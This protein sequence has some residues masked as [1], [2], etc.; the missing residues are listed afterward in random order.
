MKKIVILSFAL[1]PII[2]SAGQQFPCFSDT[3]NQIVNS[4]S[5]AQQIKTN[6]LQNYTNN[7]NNNGN[8]SSAILSSIASCADIT[9]SV[10][11]SFPTVDTFLSLIQKAIQAACNSARTAIA[12]QTQVLTNQLYINPGVAGMP[13][14]GVSTKVSGMSVPSTTTAFAFPTATVNSNPPAP[15]PST[16]TETGMFNQLKSLLGG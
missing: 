1:L 12:A 10:G 3:S 15:A 8:P 16:P 11:F 13:G 9:G 7:I 4:A 5:T 14:I 2:A 6:Q